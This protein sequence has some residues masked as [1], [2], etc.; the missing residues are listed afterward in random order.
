[1]LEV[2]VEDAMLQPGNDLEEHFRTAHLTWPGVMVDI[3][4]G[5][6]TKGLGIA[7]WIHSERL[8][9]GHDSLLSDTYRMC[10]AHCALNSGG[11]LFL[12]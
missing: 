7:D 9:E 6:S 3:S 4:K 10:E 2:V 11:W 1:M 5:A 12:L 8:V